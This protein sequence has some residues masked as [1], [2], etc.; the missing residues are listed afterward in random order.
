FVRAN[1]DYANTLGFKILYGRTLSTNPKSDS[2]AIVLNQAALIKLGID[3]KNAVGKKIFNE[4]NGVLMS[5]E[6]VGVIKDFNYRSLHEAI[7]PYGLI[8]LFS[9]EQASYLIANV[10]TGNYKNTIS[11]FETIWKRINPET[12]FEYSFLDQ[13][14]QRNYEK[15]E[16]TARIIIYFTLIAIVIAC[17][18][19]FGLAAF[20]A[21]QR[22]KEI[23]I[24]KVLGA[25]IFSITQLLS[26]DF[27]K[28]VLIANLFAL[29]LGYW[30]MTK[31]LQNFA[32]QIDISWWIFVLSGFSAITIALLTVSYQSIKAALMNP[33]KSLKTE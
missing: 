20:T 16:R 26:Y 31:W 5:K 14:F 22:T 29:P 6:I 10:N 13:Q 25:S 12:P 15:E 18:G 28:L 33:V 17:L 24:R 4:T 2:N 23:G 1:D 27:I 32:Y 9:G 3:P 8:K 30:A 19:L 21:E 11:S 7:T